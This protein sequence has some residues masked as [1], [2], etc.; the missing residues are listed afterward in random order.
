MT[1][2]RTPHLPPG[3]VAADTQ[4]VKESPGGEAGAQSKRENVQRVSRRP[5]TIP[6]YETRYHPKALRC[7]IWLT[8]ARPR[9][10]PPQS[11]GHKSRLFR[12][13]LAAANDV[14]SCT[15]CSGNLLTPSPPGEKAAAREDQVRRSRTPGTHA[16]KGVLT[17]EG[18][19]ACKL[20]GD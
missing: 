3:S 14:C 12:R 20:V 8:S 2:R 18:Q 10:V 19:H 1:Y 9:A 5:D 11:P 6:K 15:E 4:K 17:G 13:S 16:S 7:A